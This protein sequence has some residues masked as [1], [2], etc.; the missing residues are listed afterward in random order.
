M[1]HGSLVKDPRRSHISV[2]IQS[3]GSF[4]FQII[5]HELKY[6]LMQFPP[7]LELADYPSRE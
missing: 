2:I 4:E 6:P 3:F 1:I 7:G 5:R